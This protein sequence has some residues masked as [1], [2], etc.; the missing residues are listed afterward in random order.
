MSCIENLNEDC[1]LKIIEYLDLEEQLQLWQSFKP[2]SRLRSVLS[3]RWQHQTNHSLDAET[4]VQD[5]EILDVF[6]QCI[7]PTVSELTLR[8]LTMDL[9]EHW[10]NRIFP[11]LRELTYMGDENSELDGDSDI[12]ILV[13]C[14]PHLEGI[15]LSGNSSGQHISRW[16]NLRRLDL[17]LCW[18]LNTQCFEEIC[19]NLRLQTLSIQWHRAEEDAYVRAICT[20][21]E[22]QELELD[23]VHLSTENTS[24]LLRLPKLSKLRLHHFEELDDLLSDIGNQRG[25]D[26]V[27]AAFSDNIWMRPSN[28]LAK[29][30]SL[31]CLTLVDDEGCCAIDFRTTIINCFPLLEQLHLENSRIW[32]NAHGIWEVALA[33]P[34]LRDFSLS[35]QILYDEFFVFC[36]STMKRALDQRTEP[37]RM[38]FYKTGKEDLNQWNWNFYLRN[39]DP[40]E[41]QCGVL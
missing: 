40:Q 1:L 32:L 5:P 39:R 41:V 8:Y 13:G 18:Y 19:Q 35:N 4:F 21:K 23:I 14:F 26:V 16:R 24:K 20:L 12:A 25:Q 28:I 6:L 38:H 29:F 9:L 31:R 33:C 27:A 34:R 10:K 11:N 37:L 17:Q 22:L 2:T 7:Q 3:Y 15:G 30:Q 36:E